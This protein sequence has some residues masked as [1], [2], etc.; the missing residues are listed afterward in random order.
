MISREYLRRMIVQT[1]VFMCYWFRFQRKQGLAVY[2]C[3]S[4]PLSGSTTDK[5]N[6]YRQLTKNIT[7]PSNKVIY[8]TEIYLAVLVKIIVM[9]EKIKH[10]IPR[11]KIYFRFGNEVSRSFEVTRIT[12]LVISNNSFHN[13]PFRFRQAGRLRCGG[14][15]ETHCATCHDGVASSKTKQFLKSSCFFRS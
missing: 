7:E 10:K 6:F 2:R 5:T 15:R 4:V 3:R 12:F 14:A 1:S 8:S 11:E 9:N 13:L